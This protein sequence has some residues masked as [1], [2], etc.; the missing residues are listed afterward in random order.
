MFKILPKHEI[1]KLEFKELLH[2]HAHLQLAKEKGLGE[3]IIQDLQDFIMNEVEKQMQSKKNVIYKGGFFTTKETKD[4][5]G[6]H[7][8]ADKKYYVIE[9]TETYIL[10]KSEGDQEEQMMTKMWLEKGMFKFLTFH[11]E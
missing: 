2:Y 6:R 4:F 11:E 1:E 5:C 3:G 9:E 10:V 7:F 8:E